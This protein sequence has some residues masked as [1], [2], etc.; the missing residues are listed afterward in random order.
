MPMI[1]LSTDAWANATLASDEVWQC[2]E[3]TVLLSIEAPAAPDSDHGTH[4]IRFDSRTFKAG[5][6]VH[7]RRLGRDAARIAR[8]AI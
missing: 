8:E 3:G 2:R 1:T 7:Y 5:D 6:T 4:L